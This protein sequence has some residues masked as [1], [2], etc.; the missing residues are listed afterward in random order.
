MDEQTRDFNV[1]TEKRR[2]FF[3]T[4]VSCQFRQFADMGVYY[5]INTLLL[6]S[7]EFEE[8]RQCPDK[9]SFTDNKKLIK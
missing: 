6:S 7:S 5:N 8:I 1:A 9:R 4:C 2:F 3:R